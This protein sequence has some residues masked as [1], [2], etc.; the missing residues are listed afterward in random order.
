[1]RLGLALPL[2]LSH[3]KSLPGDKHCPLAHAKPPLLFP[4]FSC[5]KSEFILSIV[6]FNIVV[7]NMFYGLV[8]PS[9]VSSPFITAVPEVSTASLSDRG[10]PWGLIFILWL[11][12]TEHLELFGRKSLHFPKKTPVPTYFS[13]HLTG[14]AHVGVLAVRVICW[15]ILKFAFK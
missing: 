14:K 7:F 9:D 1:M 5:L 10:P 15:A 3:T 2:P 4:G 11:M 6:Q 13:Y 12:F 8:F